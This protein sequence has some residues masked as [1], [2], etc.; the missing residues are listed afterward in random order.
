[1]I[2]FGPAYCGPKGYIHPWTRPIENKTAVSRS[3]SVRWR[4]QHLATGMVGRHA[5]VTGQSGGTSSEILT[6]TNSATYQ[7]CARPPS[8]KTSP[9]VMKLE[10]GDARKAATAPVSEGWPM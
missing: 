9:P 6:L 10:S 8:T 3:G 5:G 1:M 4:E 2:H 7:T